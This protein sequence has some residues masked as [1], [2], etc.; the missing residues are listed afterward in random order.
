MSEEAS[1]IIL[2]HREKKRAREVRRCGNCFHCSP[3]PL[4]RLGPSAPICWLKSRPT[5]H[6]VKY[7]SKGWFGCTLHLWRR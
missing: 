5:Q 4:G 1:R 3:L 7:V 2:R 6:V